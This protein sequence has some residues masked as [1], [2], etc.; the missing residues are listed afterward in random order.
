MNYFEYTVVDNYFGRPKVHYEP[1]PHPPLSMEDGSFREW[2][3]QRATIAPLFPFIDRG[4]L[5]PGI[6]ASE[7]NRIRALVASL[8]E[9]A[10]RKGQES[11]MTTK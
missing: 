1:L 4:T 2:C 8:M 3:L 6:S 9:E 5:C 7:R 11:G 10:F